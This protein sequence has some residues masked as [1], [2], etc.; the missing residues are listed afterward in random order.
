MVLSYN[1]KLNETPFLQSHQIISPKQPE[2]RFKADKLIIEKFIEMP[3][4]DLKKLKK[5]LKSFSGAGQDQKWP[6]LF[7]LGVRKGG[8]L[9]KR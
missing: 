2:I 8:F 6:G 7:C 9:K 3:D 5:F 1:L 4:E